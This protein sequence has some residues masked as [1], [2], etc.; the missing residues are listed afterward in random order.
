MNPERPPVPLAHPAGP[1]AG[2]RVL[3]LADEKGQLGTRLLA[4]LGADVIKIEPP[5]DGDPARQHAPFFRNEAGAETSLFWWTMNAGKRSIT[6]QLKLEAGRQ[7]F[8]RLVALADI[9][10]ETT[11]PGESAALGLDYPSI[12]RANP[13]AILV[14]IT[15]FGQDGPYAGWHA[16]DIVG[17]AMGGL[18]YLN[19]DP[20][21]GPVRTTVPQAY[22]QVNVQAMVGALIAL[23]ARPLNGGRGQHVDVSMQEAVANAMDNA[24]QTWDI[25]RVN[26]SGPGL[27]RNTAG[28]RTARYLFETADGW[29]AAL[30]AGGLIGQQA[31]AIIDWLAEHGE[32]RGLDTPNGARSSPPSSRSPRKSASTS[33]RPW[34]PSAAPGRKRSLSPRPSA[35]ALAGLPSSPPRNR[36]KQAARRAGCWTRV[37][38]EDLGESFIYP[39]APFRLSVTPWMQR[40]RA[41]HIGEHNEEVY[42]GLLGLEPRS[43]AGSASGW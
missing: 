41:P 14:S 12:E 20:E 36:R 6:L 30:Q 24:Q 13:S 38:H 23:Y 2:Y 25:R 27:Y 21:R 37:T 26:A 33:R 16:T 42:C 15:G 11:M 29:V 7:L 28:I 31:N 19:G 40:G 22:T 9:V 17:A 5:R 4:E 10:V 1:L 43:S 18:M 32:A 39:G 3:D 34:P 35:A 8:H